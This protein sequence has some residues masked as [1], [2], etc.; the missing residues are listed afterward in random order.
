VWFECVDGE[1]EVGWLVY[2]WVG[3]QRWGVFEECDCHVVCGGWV[4]FDQCV[5]GGL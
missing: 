5:G 4:V 3:A 2:G 1:D